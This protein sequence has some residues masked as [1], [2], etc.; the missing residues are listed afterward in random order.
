MSN[1]IINMAIAG[2]L[3]AVC[4][5][6]EIIGAVFFFFFTMALLVIGAFA[7][8]CERAVALVC[9]RQEAGSRD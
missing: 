6:L 7:D 8:L 4:V 5:L 1:R 9:R 3:F 2:C